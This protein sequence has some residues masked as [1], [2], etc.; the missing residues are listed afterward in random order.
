MAVSFIKMQRTNNHTTVYAVKLLQVTFARAT[1]VEEF[2]LAA[3]P[4]SEKWK[5]VDI[6]VTPTKVVPFWIRDII[7]CIVRL[8]GSVKHG[9]NFAY[10]SDFFFFWGGGCYTVLSKGLT[11]WRKNL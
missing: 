8:Y 7:A 11:E 3:L 4:E 2:L 9:T 5:S 6:Q 1:D 10:N